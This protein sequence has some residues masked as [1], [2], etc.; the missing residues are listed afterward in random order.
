M[1]GPDIERRLGL[2]KELE[3][4]VGILSA[5]PGTLGIIIFGSLASGT[6]HEDS[7]IDLV[8]IRETKAPFMKRLH[9]LR[10]RLH[11][12]IATDLL[13]YTPEELASMT[14]ERAFVREE[15]LRRGKVLYERERGTLASLCA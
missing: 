13:V 5:D 12:T 6:F 4:Y 8:V 14:R 15:I 11:P 2:E 7:D 9:D 3:R 10:H 1:N